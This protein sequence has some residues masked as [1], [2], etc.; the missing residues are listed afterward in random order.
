VNV[1][2]EI[3][4]ASH[5][6]LYAKDVLCGLTCSITLPVSGA[7]NGAPLPGTRGVEGLAAEIY[8]KASSF[9]WGSAPPF[10]YVLALT[11]VGRDGYNEGGTGLCDAPEIS[12][13]VPQYGSVYPLEPGQYYKVRLKQGQLIYTTGTATAHTWWGA[14]FTIYVLNSSGTYKGTIANVPAYGATAFPTTGSAPLTYTNTGVEADFYL[15]IKSASNM[16]TDFN[17]QVQTPRLTVSPNPVVR[18]QTATFTVRGTLGGTISNWKYLPTTFAEVTRTTNT[19]ATT[20]PGIIVRGGIAQVTVTMAGRTILLDSPQLA[21]TARSGWTLAAG[22]H[23]EQNAGFTTP[24]GVV[25]APP[26]PPTSTAEVGGKFG[27]E[28]AHSFLHTKITDQGP[29]HGFHYVTSMSDVDDSTSPPKPTKFY[30]VVIDSLKNSQS[31]FY[32]KQ[33]GNYHETT[34]PNGYI[35]GANLLA[36]VRRHEALGT[37]SHY[38]Q[39]VNAQNDPANNLGTGAE[40]LVGA[41]TLTDQ[42]FEDQVNDLM[43]TKR[44]A[45]FAA[46]GQEPYDVTRT[47]SNVFMGYLNLPPYDPNAGC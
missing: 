12:V 7:V 39:Y 4:T 36:G 45:I 15:Q 33:C 13:E 16:T 31:T 40:A 10:D 38:Q 11:K 14:N 34:N 44:A 24:S 9:N 27:L 22:T 1:R 8:I 42:Q 26:D 47:D 6:I 35:S 30:W 28:L 25:L 37:N 29:N 32:S 18:G 19:A 5:H 21:V 20:W 23:S 41:P 3:R 17:F 2:F 46:V 43:A